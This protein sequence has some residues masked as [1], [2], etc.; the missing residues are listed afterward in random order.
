MS[1]GAD[2]GRA[3]ALF[4][5]AEP[6]GEGAAT[7]QACGPRSVLDR[8]QNPSE[9]SGGFF[10]GPPERGETGGWLCSLLDVNIAS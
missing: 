5:P 7:P 6:G 4:L 2:P 1:R 3:L 8:T 10:I 9:I